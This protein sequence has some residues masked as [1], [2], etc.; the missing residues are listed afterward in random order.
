MKLNE[1]S[2]AHYATC[3]SPPDKTG[4]L[5]KKGERNTAYHRRWFVL[6][7]NM[8]FYFEE[9]DSREPIGV[10]VLEGCTV[11]LCESVEEFAFAIKFDCAKARVYKLA[12]ENQAA[13]ESWV[14]A[15]SRASFDYMRLVVKELERQLEEIQDAA[16]A[17][18]Q[19]ARPKPS[20]RNQV[21]RSRS[22]ASSSSSSSSSLSSSSSAPSMAA[23]YS[24]QKMLQD[25]VQLISGSSRENGVAWSK[26]PSATANGS[27]EAAP[28]CMTWDGCTDA[29]TLSGC[30]GDGG[31][32]PPV[33]PRRLGASLESPVSPDTACF[34][35]LHDWYGREVEELRAQWL[36]SQ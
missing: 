22:G 18:G 2:V 23:V 12:A 30:A 9:R 28:S 25:E 21:A 6:K 15:L 33:P 14:K 8:L 16:G 5:F 1:R 31:R 24:A 36:Q 13:M 20:R 11:E 27:A 26:P 4:F 19:Q 3:D 7:G 17:G 34:S 10:I 32:A 29:G 35:K